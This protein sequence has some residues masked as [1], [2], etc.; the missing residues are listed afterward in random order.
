MGL[1][2]QSMCAWLHGDASHCG[3]TSP[4]ARPLPRR[5]A[6]V[7]WLSEC[8]FTPEALLGL[9]PLPQAKVLNVFDCDDS[10]RS[11]RAWAA[12]TEVAAR[13]GRLEKVVVRLRSPP[14]PVQPAAA[15]DDDDDDESDGEEE[16]G[17]AFP[18][19]NSA[20]QAK[21]GLEMRGRG[22]VRIELVHDECSAM[23]Y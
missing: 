4:P 21:A 12:L 7:L 20:L 3:P 8:T 11:S 23:D 10:M 5:C 17:D 2:T 19:R 14:G 15:S 22:A 1:P 13:S 6:Q 9:G 16:D 18:W